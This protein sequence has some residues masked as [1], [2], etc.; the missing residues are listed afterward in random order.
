MERLNYFKPFQSLK[1][2]HEDQLTRAFLVVLRHVPLALSAFID[3]VRESME[4]NE[5]GETLPPLSALANT[6]LEMRTQVSSITDKTGNLVSIVMTDEEWKPSPEFKVEHDDRTPRYDGVIS[7]DPDWIL[8]I[9]NKPYHGDIWEEQLNPNLAGASEITVVDDHVVI[10][11]REVITRLTSICERDLVSGAERLIVDEFLEFVEDQFG[12]LNPY[13]KLSLCKDH[14]YRLRNRCEVILAQLSG[15]SVHN[16]AGF[17]D[18]I[19]AESHAFSDIYLYVKKTLPNQWS[20]TL[21]LFPG[22]TMN[23]AR[24]LYA[25][26]NKDK[27][28]ALSRNQS[29]WTMGPDM[30]FAFI[31]TNLCWT[32]PTLDFEHFVE[33]W[34]NSVGKIQRAERGAD[35]FTSAISALEQD[36]LLS[37]D[38]VTKFDDS[39]VNTKRLYMNVCP[40]IAMSYVWPKIEAVRLDEQDML[41]SEVR[42][43]IDEAMSC[44]GESFSTATEP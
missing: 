5:G 15:S 32:T 21:D 44:W 1:P 4:K 24:N 8:V 16:R 35:S 42:K 31:A 27:L 39:F 19:R 14:D 29:G 37:K 12:S 13:S 22:N 23:Q 40:G 2:N 30:H 41:V 10:I 25:A 33:F 7:L 3:L 26:L 34:L 28:L 6:T 38:D 11:W 36:G 20:L 17:K 18:F 43:R 9:E